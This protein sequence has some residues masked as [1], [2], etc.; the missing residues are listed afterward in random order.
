MGKLHPLPIPTKPWDSIGMDFIG[1]FPESKG[2]NYL[3]VVICRMTSMVHLIPVH[4]K[5]T[6]TELSWVY[7]REIVRLHGLP[8][9]IVSDRDSKFTSKW[10][11]ELHRILGARLLMSTSFH[12]QT[13]GQTER[14][15]RNVGQIFRAVVWHDQK[16]WV[17]RVDM[18]EFTI[19][20]SV[21]ETTKYAPFKLNGGHMPSMIKELRSDEVIPKGIKAFVDQALQNLAEAHDLI[22]EARVFQ[23]RNANTH[24]GK[25]PTISPGDLV[26]LATKNL[27]LPK[28][29]VRKLCPKY[30]GPYKVVKAD[31]SNSTYTLDLPVALQERRIV[32]KFHI[33]L[34][35]PYIA[36]SDA[37]FPNRAHPEPYDFGMADDHEWFVDEILGHRWKKGTKLGDLEFEI[38]WSLGEHNVGTLQEL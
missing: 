13:D 38:W 28:G 20:A 12:P 15:N 6:A 18:T 3:W 36:S 5:I 29:R 31:P 19:N 14:A 7:H 2:F 22:I 17:D 1:P 11:R 10:W 32:P 24:R 34:L 21:S 23:T 9:L 25:E 35:R 26:Y 16:D 27:N 33:A 8:S 37:L 4:T 30:V